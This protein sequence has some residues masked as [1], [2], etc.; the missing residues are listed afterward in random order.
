MKGNENRAHTSRVSKP[1]V[2][3]TQ[4]LRAAQLQPPPLTPWRERTQSSKCLTQ[5]I[6][7]LCLTMQM[8]GGYFYLQVL[9]ERV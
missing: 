5:I 9:V 6:S 4:P 8:Q 3:W 2:P 1:P 7:H